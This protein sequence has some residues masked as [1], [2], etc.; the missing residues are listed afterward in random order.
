[1]TLVCTVCSVV[2]VALIVVESTS[3]QALQQAR[4]MIRP[5]LPSAI[6][7]GAFEHA[8]FWEEHGEVLREAWKEFA[9]VRTNSFMTVY[10]PLYL[11][12]V[13]ALFIDNNNPS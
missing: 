12:A 7:G 5:P 2:V 13:C 1:M 11:V 6:E 10:F 3:S 4:N 8:D 9:M